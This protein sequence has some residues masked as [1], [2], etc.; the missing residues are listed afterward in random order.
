MRLSP[1]PFALL[2]LAASAPAATPTPADSAM[3]RVQDAL[4]VKSRLEKAVHEMTYM[5]RF[6]AVI[7]ND[8]RDR[9]CAEASQLVRAFLAGSRAAHPMPR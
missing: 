9:A 2:L 1:L 8:D 7:V 6:D 5:D 3:K 4:E